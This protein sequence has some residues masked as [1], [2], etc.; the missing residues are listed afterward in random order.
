LFCVAAAA[1]VPRLRLVLFQE[2]NVFIIVLIIMP[3]VRPQN[4][5]D[6]FQAAAK[7]ARQKQPELTHNQKVNAL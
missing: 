1:A 4:L 2:Q 3:L 6:V 5:N 7:M